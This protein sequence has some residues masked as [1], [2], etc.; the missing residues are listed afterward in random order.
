VQRIFTVTCACG[1]RFPV[2]YGIRFEPV[3]LECPACRR[4]FTVEEA[5]D[6]DERWG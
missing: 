2:D 6:L 3:R 5:A 4:Q 1:H